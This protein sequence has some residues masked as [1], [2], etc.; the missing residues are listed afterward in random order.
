MVDDREQA[1]GG[2]DDPRRDD[3]SI[4]SRPAPRYRALDPDRIVATIGA[5]RMRIEGR[6]P[7][8]GL[9]AVCEELHEIA[10]D[11]KARSIAIAKPILALRIASALL[12]VLIVSATITVLAGARLPERSLDAGELVQILEAA[13]NDV[14]LIGAAIFFLVSLETRIKRNRALKALHELRAVAHII[15]MHQLT[16]DPEQLM[17]VDPR[18]VVWPREADAGFLLTRYL[19]YASEM[20]SLAG[21]LAAL[22]VQHFDDA[23]ALAAVNEVEAL[24]TGLSRKIWQKI[25]IIDSLRAGTVVTED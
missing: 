23:G 21:K 1:S 12:T 19:D 10:R 5:L 22:Y 11:A 15:D 20:L 4:A 17:S 16:K 7:E 14:V 13:I 25:T 18:E 3:V 6:F 24:C 8:S 9:G 2:Q